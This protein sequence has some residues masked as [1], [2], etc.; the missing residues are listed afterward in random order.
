MHNITNCLICDGTKFLHITSQGD[1]F[2]GEKVCLCSNCGMVF[3][4]P[5]LSNDELDKFYSQN[6]F[7]ELFRGNSTPDDEIIK[8]R[9]IRAENKMVLI[10]GDLGAAPAGDVLE[11]GCSSGNLLKLIRKSGRGVKGI[12]PSDSFAKYANEVYNIDV[13]S[14]MFPDALGEAKDTTFSI[15]IMLHVLEHVS[16]P[17]EVL[18]AIH[19]R[20]CEGGMLI[21]E[22]PDVHQAAS[23]RKYLSSNYFQKSH[24]WDF[25]ENSLRSL[26]TKCGFEISSSKHYSSVYPSDKNVLFVAIKGEASSDVLPNVSYSNP[27]FAQKLNSQ[28]KFKLLMGTFVGLFRNLLPGRPGKNH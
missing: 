9:V 22:V 6:E 14:G 11:I 1:H 5:R 4:S 17:I 16:D 20:L 24:L 28:L 12:D 19:E 10:E 13:V 23:T 3:L 15:I 21:V 27:E 25:N 8:A 26:L 7:S 2:S 18:K